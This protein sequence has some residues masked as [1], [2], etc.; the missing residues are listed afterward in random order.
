MQIRATHTETESIPE[1]E[2]PILQ[3]LLEL[4]NALEIENATFKIDLEKLSRS[5]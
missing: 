1:E 2:E 5:C 4:K 3:R